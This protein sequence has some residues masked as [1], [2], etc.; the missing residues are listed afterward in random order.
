MPYLLTLLWILLFPLT[1]TLAE[2]PGKIGIDD[3]RLGTQIPM[4]LIF[5]D[6]E[7]QPVTLEQVAGSRPFL[8]AMVYY[9]CSS[10]CSPF[11][12]GIAD[13]VRISPSQLQPGTDYTIVTISFNPEE[14]P[15]L[16]KAKKESYFNLLGAE[17]SPDPSAW[18]FL[19]GD[20]NNIRRLTDAIGFHYEKEGSEYNHAS[21]LIAIS[22]KGRIARYLRGLSFLPVEVMMAVLDAREDRWAPTIR[23]VVAFCFTEDP[24]GSGY[25]F[26]VLRVFGT[27]VALALTVFA[28][29]LFFLNRKGR[30]LKP[31][32]DFS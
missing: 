10:I 23:K 6:E 3:S 17:K 14:G 12:N 22:A 30:S 4:D 18:R 5:L 20:E 29:S 11:L 16:A 24:Q 26:N 19:T 15:S 7:G 28:V 25:Y 21:S 13:M 31:T 9:N 32:E 27:L 2:T 8:L 1:Q